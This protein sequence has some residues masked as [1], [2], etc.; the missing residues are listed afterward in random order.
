MTNGNWH[1]A[2]LNNKQDWQ[3]AEAALVIPETG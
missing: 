3:A 2:L 1:G